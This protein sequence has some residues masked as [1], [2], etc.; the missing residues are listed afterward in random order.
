MSK[1]DDIRQIIEEKAKNGEINDNEK[2]ALLD[3]VDDKENEREEKPLKTFKGVQIPDSEEMPKEI[4]KMLKENLQSIEY[5]EMPKWFKNS[6]W[7]VN[8][9]NID[10]FKAACA[11]TK[12][13]WKD[14]EKMVELHYTGKEDQFYGNRTIIIYVKYD[15]QYKVK[16]LS[17]KLK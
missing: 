8:F 14:D 2:E 7:N 1:Y 16:T 12:V 15:A 11:I 17:S 3:K 5:K 10:Q 4:L 13:I 9:K 6:T